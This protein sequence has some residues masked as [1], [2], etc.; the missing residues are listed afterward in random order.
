[1]RVEGSIPFSMT[2]SWRLAAGIA[3]ITL[4]VF[5]PALLNGFVWDDDLNLLLNL[6]YRGLGAHQLRAAVSTIRG[7]Q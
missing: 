4:A 1:M 7:G 2:R 6:D 5:S 3:A